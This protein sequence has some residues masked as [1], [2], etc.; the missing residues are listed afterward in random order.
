MKRFLILQVRPEDSAADSEFEAILRAGGLAE[1]R[2]ERVRLD[3]EP[4]PDPSALDGY[5]GIILGG[6]PGCVS[7][8]P[9]EKPLVEANI[10]DGVLSLMPRV[11]EADIPFM[12]CCY[13]MSI[14]A[15][16]LG[17]NVERGRWSEPVGTARCVVTEAGRVDPLLE[18]L[19]LEWTA[20][21]GHKEAAEEPIPGAVVLVGAETCPVQMIRHKSNV[22]A[23]Q[24]H[25]EADA[26]EFELRIRIYR[27][28][29]YFPPEDADRLTALC[30]AADV[31]VPPRILA[32][33]VERHGG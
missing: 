2:V 33:F 30:R 1:A 14:L 17:G 5:A 31:R 11:C 27:D 32:R 26:A 9:D 16:H 12:G 13:G 7:D 28:R 19:G 18:G 24:F 4:P 3:R 21:V 22:Y 23:T 6:G 8:P 15:H 25:P 29:G 10:E 20:F